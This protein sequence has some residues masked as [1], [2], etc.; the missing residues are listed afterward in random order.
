M[1]K[2]TTGHLPNPY[3]PLR[4]QNISKRPGIVAI[5][6]VTQI[7]WE[8]SV[9]NLQQQKARDRKCTTR[10]RKCKQASAAALDI[11]FWR[12]STSS[13]FRCRSWSDSLLLESVYVWKCS[14]MIRDTPR[15]RQQIVDMCHIYFHLIALLSMQC[16][17]QWDIAR[18]CQCKQGSAA[19][20]D[21][22]FRRSSTSAAFCVRSWSDS[23]MLDWDIS[24]HARRSPGKTRVKAK[25]KHVLPI[26]AYHGI[27]A[28]LSLSI[29]IS[30]DFSRAISCNVFRT[31]GNPKCKQASAAAL[32]N[33]FRKSSTSSAFR[34]RSWS[35]SLML[36]SVHVWIRSG[37]TREKTN[38][39]KSQAYLA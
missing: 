16:P 21:N 22:C 10:N 17:T 37:I 8:A 29:S 28:Y 26:C 6:A 30:Q 34:C 39:R 20:L 5:H 4:H 23:L 36:E 12:S 15:L 35:D 1:W 33:C 31:M 14:G 18:S 19:A 24:G 32:D 7:L 9:N 25:T 2:E 3:S 11:C 13:A 27:S 38:K